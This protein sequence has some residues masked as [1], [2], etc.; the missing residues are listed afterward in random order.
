MNKK[1]VEPERLNITNLRI[2]HNATSINNDELR[3]AI[4]NSL[5]P[6]SL[7]Q[8]GLEKQDTTWIRHN[9]QLDIPLFSTTNARKW[10]IEEVAAYVEHITSITYSNPK[11]PN[12]ISDRFVHQV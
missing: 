10:S 7:R 9:A 11:N 2:K 4:G 6:N 12:R 8:C 3:N 1:Q 5:I